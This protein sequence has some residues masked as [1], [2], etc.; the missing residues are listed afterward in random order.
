MKYVPLLL[1]PFFAVNANAET[2]ELIPSTST[3]YTRAQ[4]IEKYNYVVR[5]SM[6]QTSGTLTLFNDL[7]K[8][9]EENDKLDSI[10]KGILQAISAQSCGDYLSTMPN[11]VPS[12]GTVSE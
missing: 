5:Y 10:N 3:K 11:P 1:L 9:Q 2:F 4:L 7:I 8:E 6:Q 12:T